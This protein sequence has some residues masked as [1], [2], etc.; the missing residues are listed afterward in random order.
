MKNLT[1]DRD[2]VAL[3]EK[4]LKEVN[5]GFGLLTLPVIGFISGYLYEKYVS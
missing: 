3:G 5:G 2:L 1:L 4:E